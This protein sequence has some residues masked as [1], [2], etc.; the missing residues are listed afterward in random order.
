MQVAHSS[1]LNDTHRVLWHTFTM[2]PPEYVP[3]TSSASPPFGPKALA[4]RQSHVTEP[5][6]SAQ[7]YMS[8]KQT[9]IGLPCHLQQRF[10][11]CDTSY[12]LT[13]AH[14]FISRRREKNKVDV[15]A[16]RAD[17][18]RA[19]PPGQGRGRYPRPGGSPECPG[20][21]ALRRAQDGRGGVPPPPEKGR[22]PGGSSAT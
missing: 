3:G 15:C 11:C 6:P 10:L 5:Q 8:K 21:A 13:P 2:C 12:A 17:T 19:F 1:E 16:A 22:S 4:A 20:T 18:P 14:A 9:D 7:N